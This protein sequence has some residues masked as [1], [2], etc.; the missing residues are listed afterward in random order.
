VKSQILKR[1]DIIYPDLSYRI[2]GILFEIWNEIGYGYREKYYQKALA[3]AFKRL[4]VEFKEQLPYKI[5]CRGEDI[6][7]CF[8]D[9]LIENK[10][11]LELKRGEYFS[12]SNINQVYA[13]L[14]TTGLKLG[15]IA[16]FTSKGLRFKRIVNLI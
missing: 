1:D 11:I 12:K 15:I 10:M 9:F 3:N 14:K 16:N 5:K 6:G 4:D 13:Y 8:L 7:I 2:I